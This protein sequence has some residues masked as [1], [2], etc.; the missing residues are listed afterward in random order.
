MTIS[1]RPGRRCRGLF[2]QLRGL[3]DPGYMSRNIQS[4]ERINSTSETNVTILTSVTLV[5]DWFLSVYMSYASQNFLFHEFN[6]SAL[7]FEFVCSC[8]RSDCSREAEAGL[9]RAVFWLASQ[10]SGTG[11]IVLERLLRRW[12]RL[13]SDIEVICPRLTHK[14]L[15]TRIKDR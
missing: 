1:R 3:S 13:S 14:P 15:L 5:N 7:S 2:L 9:R 4:L 8:S 11:M 6:L 12:Y 10:Q